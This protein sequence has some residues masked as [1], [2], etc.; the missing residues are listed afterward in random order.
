[1][2]LLDILDISGSAMNVQSQKMNVHANNIANIDNVIYK[3]K[4][5]YPYIA[6]KAILKNYKNDNKIG[7]VYIDKII[8]DSSPCKLLYDPNNPRSNKKGYIVTSN[9]NI[10]AEMVNSIA[11]ARNYQAN[12]EIIHTVQSMITKTLNIGQ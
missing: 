1:M 6:K 12:I 11:A 3:N 5:Y 2:S 7:Q 8:D 10:V 4:K 9:V